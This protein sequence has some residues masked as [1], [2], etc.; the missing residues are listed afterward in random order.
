MEDEK[1]VKILEESEAFLTGHFRLSSGLH[2]GN[3]LQCAQVFKFPQHSETLSALLVEKVRQ[4]G[5]DIDT[6]IS[7]ALGG[8]LFGY[9]VSRQ[10]GVPNIFAERDAEAR[11]TVRRGFHVRP[12]ER[13]LAVEDVITTGGSVREVIELVRAAGGIIQA[14]G[15]VA[16]RSRGQALFDVPFFSLIRL[17]F[18]TYD[19]AECPLCQSGVPVE[20]PGSRK[21]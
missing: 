2:S 6:V 19:P 5:I 12:G 20:K 15:C 16:D 8:V 21:A 11:M 14:V 3:Y 13:F 9:E 18:A 1:I 4:A 7:P 17:E 10:A